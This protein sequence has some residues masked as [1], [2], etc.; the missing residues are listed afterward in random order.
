MDSEGK[1]VR[2]AL[3][4][5]FLGLGQPQPA[6]RVS[7][8][9]GSFE[10]E[11]LSVG[12]H[13]VRFSAKGFMPGTQDIAISNG[14]VSVVEM[15]LEKGECEVAGRTTDEEDRPVASEVSLLR[16][17]IVIQKATTAKTSGA[18]RFRNLT[19]GAY[20]V[21][22]T[23]ACHATRAWTGKVEATTRVDLALPV[24]EGCVM[25]GK[26][27]VC[28]KTKEVKYCKFC[29]AFICDGCRHNYPA[30]MRAMIRRRLS[31]GGVADEAAVQA[32]YEKELQSQK[33]APCVTC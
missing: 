22:A 33:G 28:G 30:R 5:T 10:F 6:T 14:Q 13:F 23:S 4:E 25:S 31:K 7:Y 32:A 19:Q 3:I 15:K 26:C 20:E 8:G 24:V 17:G 11:S 9:D 21:Q 12:N 29:H 2:G 1:P 18:Y 16:R 27:D